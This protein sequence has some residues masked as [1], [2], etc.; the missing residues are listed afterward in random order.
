MPTPDVRV[1][2]A[3]RCSLTPTLAG[4]L[5]GVSIA[6]ALAGVAAAQPA[7]PAPTPPS[8]AVAADPGD[9]H[10][11]QALRGLESPAAAAR[12]LGWWREARFGMF[13]HWGL[14]SQD[15]CFWKGQDGKTE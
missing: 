4:A 10:D 13:I 6:L 11:G 5:A 7:G 12:R 9:H 1:E 14:Y 8:A 2:P 15:G 3:V